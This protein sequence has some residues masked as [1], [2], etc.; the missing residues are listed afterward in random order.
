MNRRAFLRL[1]AF[2]LAACVLSQT[3]KAQA[4]KVAAQTLFL[5]FDIPTAI[6]TAIGNRPVIIIVGSEPTDNDVPIIPASTL[7]PTMPTL[8]PTVTLEPTIEPPLVPA[9]IHS[10]YVP[11]VINDR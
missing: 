1:G 2:Y 6:P 8:E 5:G 3:P 7:E 9:E 11:L 10:Y 4:V